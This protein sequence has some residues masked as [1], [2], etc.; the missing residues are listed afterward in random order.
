MKTITLTWN[1]NTEPDLAGYHVYRAP[2]LPTAPGT[3]VK[4]ASVGKVTTYQDTVSVDGDYVYALRAFDS[5]NNISDQ[6]NTP[7]VTVNV[8]PPAAP[9]NLRAIVEP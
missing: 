2:G 7:G 4:I 9:Q 3:F 8:N 1:P 6:S 5:A